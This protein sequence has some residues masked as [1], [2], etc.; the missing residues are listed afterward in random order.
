MEGGDIVSYKALDVAKYIVTKCYM[1]NCPVTN[2]QIQK[3]LYY[4]QKDFLKKG[5]V[6][7][8]DEIE[9]WQFG[10][11][12]PEVYYFFCGNGSMRILSVYF[13]HLDASFTNKIDGIIVEKRVLRPW[14]LVA[15]THEPGKAWSR[16]YNGGIGDHRVIPKELIRMCG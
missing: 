16:I 13:N 7:F 2:L 15:D 14:D 12:V 3:I 4:I 5:T 8:D 11:V 9:A 6:A 1:E 10:P